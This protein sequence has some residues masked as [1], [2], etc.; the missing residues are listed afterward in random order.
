MPLAIDF[1][2]Y[3]FQKF[4][5]KWKFATEPFVERLQ[6]EVS[7]EAA[8]DNISDTPARSRRVSE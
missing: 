7:R 8:A 1:S 3:D 5:P 2:R 6:Q 4:A